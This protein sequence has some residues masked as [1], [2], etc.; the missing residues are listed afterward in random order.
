VRSLTVFLVLFWCP[1]S[2]FAQGEEGQ[3]VEAEADPAFA[4]FQNPAFPSPPVKAVPIERGPLL[5]AAQVAPY[6]AEGVAAQAKAEFDAG[7]YK[8]ARELF[9]SVPATAPV[10]FIKALAA[11]RQADFDSAGKEFEALSALDPPLR[12]R[13]LVHAGQS[14]EQLK[15][16]E[17]AVRVYGQVSASSRLLPDARFGLARALKWLKSPGPA[18]DRLKD[19]VDR[20]P[21]PWGRDLGAE[22]LLIAADV[23]AFKGNAKAEKEALLKLW[24]RHPLAKEA[25]KAEA[26]LGDVSAMEPEQ[27]VARGDALIDAHHNAD[28][29]AII[30]PLLESLKL[31]DPLACRAHWAMGKAQR[32]LRQHAKAIATLAP[33]VKKCRDPE[34]R[35]KALSTLGFSQVFAAPQLAAGTYEQLAH[36]YPEHALADDALFFA[37]ESHLRRGERD[38]G[39]ALLFELAD[40]YPFGD[41]AADAL[42]K[43]FWTWRAE[44]HG[45][46]AL[47]F[48][49]E[50]EGR[51]ATSEDSY[52]LERA[53]YWRARALETAGQGA[54]AIALY[55]QEAT[56]HPATY[57]GL[58]SRE[59]VEAL[60]PERAAA[61]GAA[62]AASTAPIP[63]LPMYAGPL[64]NDPQFA[65]AVELLRLGLGELVPMEI[66]AVDRTELP[67]D[68]IRLMVLVLSLAGETR[69][70]HGLARIWLRHDL[71]GP[72]SAERRGVWELAYP[73]AFR[74]E[75]RSSAKLA[76]ELDPDLLQGLMREE[77]ALDPRA[78]SWA[79]ALGLCQLMPA[80]AAEVAG[81]LKLKR[82]TTAALLE[83][84][85]NLRL[86]GRYLAD[87]LIRAK[88]TKQFAIAA[89]NAGEGSVSHWRK[90]NGD[91]DLAE[92][93]EQIPVQE[94][95]AYV[96]RVLRSY[97]TY[98]LLY[99]PGELPHTVG[100]PPTK[101]P[102]R[103][104]K[105]G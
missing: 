25:S 92:W 93:V 87:L 62:V 90:E 84:E 38:E 8:H 54:A 100:P 69:A 101:A 45:D 95:R 76:D 88:G 28:G 32:K 79:G 52:E 59:K 37:A 64:M 23:Q 86:G 80:T 66:L 67:P 7:R 17:A 10:R 49:E 56:E 6:F 26:R 51:F 4:R 77:S 40:R 60:A 13:C 12:D 105:S 83:P 21:P 9:D 34:L 3:G 103:A 16:W 82:P 5:T 63:M 99:S 57:Y 33:V 47:Q 98:K 94:T 68:S 75:V 91:A 70:A 44:Q 72:I 20:P 78:L 61:L 46:E 81:Q 102:T 73:R 71:S 50:I 55:E 29:A 24:S 36:D 48:L 2:S 89:Y 96:K 14:Y 19:Y 43:L 97:N 104:A 53:R 18:L 65:S 58:I 30:E 11:L 42:F 31:P 22:A 27:L 74:D 85:L 15:Q 41:M 1:A 35:V 39:V